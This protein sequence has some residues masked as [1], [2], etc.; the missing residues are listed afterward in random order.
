MAA[1]ILI[2]V[3]LFTACGELDMLFPS[4][5]SYQVKILVNSGSLEDC[6]IISSADQIQPYFTVSVADDPD[7]I[8]LL[9]YIQN[10]QG[11]IVGEKIRYTLQHQADG[12]VQPETEPEKIDPAESDPAQTDPS[13]SDSSQTDSADADL[14]EADPIDTDLAEVDPQDSED[15]GFDTPEASE[16]AV[17]PAPVPEEWTVTKKR[18]FYNNRQPKAGESD[19]IELMVK[20]LADE[21][22]YFRLSATL[23]TGAYTIVFEALGKKE[24]L[25]RT[26]TNIFYVGSAEFDFK[27]I[28]MY[29]PEGSISRLIPP[30]TLVMLEAMLD[31]DSRFDPYIIWR[32]GKTIISQGKI[33]D[34]AGRV[35]WK[36]PEQAG[37]YSLRLEVFPFQLGRTFSGIS[38]DITLPVSPKAT[39]AGYFF[40][41]DSNY[42]ALSPLAE[43]TAYREH[44]RLLTEALSAD[45]EE[46]QTPEL[47]PLLPLSSFL[48]ELLQW[49]QFKGD[50]V[51]S[52]NLARSL[53]PAN[54]RIPQWA[55][56]GL[57]YGLNMELNNAY[58]LPSINF[59]RK[60]QNQG[61]GI[62]LFHIT[63]PAQGGIF[64]AFFPLRSS[65]TEGA[66]MSISRVQNAIVLSLSAKGYTIAIPLSLA[67]SD[68]QGFIPI[69]AEVY[70]LP[71]SIEAKLSLGSVQSE[72][73]GLP[74]PGPLTGEA[75]ITLSQ[76]QLTEKSIAVEIPDANDEG[77][78]DIAESPETP[79][80]PQDYFPVSTIW[81]EFAV[82]FSALPLI[83]PEVIAPA[84]TSEK[85]ELAE[86]PAAAQAEMPEE[87][88]APDETENDF[89][90]LPSGEAHEEMFHPDAETA[91]MPE[92]E[93]EL[94]AMHQEPPADPL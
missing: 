4:N 74:L 72:A 40:N 76:Y 30:G 33:I 87:T 57:S 28:L 91:E 22:P 19:D 17:I 18:T 31:F 10:D 81:N 59:F 5:G 48:P 8:G 42:T 56:A 13:Q 16:A 29:L 62:F 78:P 25:S 45:S 38:R 7:L 39:N 47:P 93:S 41:N 80:S 15:A 52:T 69:L 65:L 27:D 84:D 54:K 58:S 1:I 35:F 9:V 11:R 92:A 26:E 51:D 14:D 34:G 32:N 61:G 2:C 55:P 60:E 79:N 77:A 88:P 70:I 23:E 94:P 63:P 68:P 6:S 82:L 64:S 86:P 73:K 67:H 46:A 71:D 36:A 83:I 66:L 85:A 37:F 20:S 43:G 24:T 3:S 21:L 44:S 90:E 75:K 53:I 50:L 12:A 49:Y 89:A